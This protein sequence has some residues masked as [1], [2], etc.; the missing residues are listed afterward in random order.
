[1]NNLVFFDSN[2]MIGQ[3]V[4]DPESGR[5]AGHVDRRALLASMDR[6]GVERA[7]VT[8]WRA[9]KTD[10]LPMNEALASE[11]EGSDRLLPCF[12]VLPEHVQD[13][14]ARARLSDMIQ[15]AGARAA[16]IPFG[17]ATLC[18]APWALSELFGFLQERHMLVFL[19]YPYLGV[20]VPE[21]DD[22]Y[23]EAL[24]SLLEGFPRLNVVTLGRLRGFYPLMARHGNLF[25]SLAWDPYPDF[26]EDV[27]R[28]FGSGR[29]L[30]GTPYCENAKDISGM[31]MMM[32]AHAAV[33]EEDRARVAGKNLAGLLGLPAPQGSPVLQKSAFR[34]ALRPGGIRL[35]I[36]DVHTHVGSW[37]AEYKPAF[38]V[39]ELVRETSAFGP[40][41]IYINSTE[42]VTGGDHVRANAE[43]AEAVRARP[44]V[45]RGIYIFN[46]EFQ[47]GAAALRRAITSDGFSGVK[48]HPRMHRCAVTDPRLV[49]VWEAAE[50]FNAPVLCHTGQGQAFSEP[51]QFAE[52]APRYPKARFIM[53]HTGETLAGMEQCVRLLN[54]FDNMYVDVSGWLFM[55]RGMLEY[56]VRRVPRTH[57]L[58]G[59]DYSWID[60]R[61]ALA[62]VL[63]ADIDEE[64]KQ[65]IFSANA[66]RVFKS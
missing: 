54:R 35:S 3:P 27:T 19:H 59:S 42:A 30:F 46:P 63:F 11:I 8:H 62:T 2:A 64:T 55:K 34:D 15:R 57:I 25:T 33:S 50:A 51:D 36:T 16:R 12:T 4:F 61:Y 1:M 58:Y 65:M 23:L 41:T 9:L 5:F 49:P 37:I 10:P 20:A 38:G 56:L 32:V 47:D 45:L 66:A 52:I 40:S 21:R 26:V 39:E 53:A 28:R 43:I 24:D 22:P 6:Y 48:V 44:D 18:A 29:I 31:P 60:V 14:A 7:L 13:A 17:E